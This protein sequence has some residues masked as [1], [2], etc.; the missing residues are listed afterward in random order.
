M[1]TRNAMT[2]KPLEQITLVLGGA[3]SGKS[4]A[5]ETLCL[6][7]NLPRIYIATAQIYD[8]EMRA[9]VDQHKLE[10]GPEWDTIEAPQDV[11]SV[12]QT[13]PCTQVI[14][15]DCLTMWLTNHMLVGADIDAETTK[16]I[17]ALKICASPVVLVS[18][19]VGQGIVPDN[20]LA[21][22]FRVAQGRLNRQIA[23]EA[24]CVVGVMAGLPFALKGAL[25][26]ALA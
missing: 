2:D 21:R 12:L 14:L 20:A 13:A 18:N 19:E 3:S 1:D 5:A 6:A 16:L 24:D 11:A 10:R 8:D 15:I 23:A 22:K 4:N 17:D 9:T 25:P 26:D 7:Q